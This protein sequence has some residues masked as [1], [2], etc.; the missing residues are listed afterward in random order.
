MKLKPKTYYC[1]HCGKKHS[2]AYMADICF[3]LDL[4]ILTFNENEQ[5]KK[6]KIGINS[7]QDRR[8]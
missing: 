3:Q 8:S 5:S 6:S 2:Y 1:R 7:E 4:K